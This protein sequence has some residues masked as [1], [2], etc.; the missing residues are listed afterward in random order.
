MSGEQLLSSI[1]TLNFINSLLIDEK[2]ISSIPKK[3]ETCLNKIY[4]FLISKSSNLCNILSFKDLE[5]GTK[6][7]FNNSEIN[8]LISRYYKRNQNLTY[9][10]N[11][12]HLLD[13]SLYLKENIINKFIT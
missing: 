1:I 3:F 7:N 9:L 13:F 12:I 11:N 6:D 2:K 5:K 10:R 8:D 4:K